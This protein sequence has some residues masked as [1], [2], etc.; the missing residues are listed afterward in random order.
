[1]PSRPTRRLAQADLKKGW[2]AKITVGSAMAAE[3]Q[4]N[5]S[6]VASPAPDQTATDSSMTFIMLNPATPSRIS[7]SRPCLSVSVAL[8]RPG[9]SSCA[10]YPTPFSTPISR[11][12]VTSGAAS[13]LTRRRVRFTRALRT[14]S[15]FCRLCSTSEMQAAQ[16]AVGSDSISRAP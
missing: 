4:W 15:T 5:R 12:A 13:T 10:S 8:S 16:C 2:P 9:S 3:I 7:R 14:P 6:R 1:M 11:S